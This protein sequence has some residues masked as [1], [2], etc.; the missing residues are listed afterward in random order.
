MKPISV[1]HLERSARPA[2]D[3][4]AVMR[5]VG[6]IAPVRLRVVVL[7]IFSSSTGSGTP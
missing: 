1:A 5:T 3:T 7:K 6:R 2:I 4:L